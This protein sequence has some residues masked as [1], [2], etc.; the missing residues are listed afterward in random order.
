MD[1]KTIEREIKSLTATI[2][3]A[4]EERQQ[5]IEDA[6]DAGVDDATIDRW[7]GY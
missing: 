3:H 2:E 7:C 1:L 5:W 4:E 6:E